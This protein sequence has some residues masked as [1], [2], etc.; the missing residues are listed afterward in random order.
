MYFLCHS[1]SPFISEQMDRLTCLRASFTYSNS[2]FSPS[3]RGS[4]PFSLRCLL[5]PSF[6]QAVPRLSYRW[7]FAQSTSKRLPPLSCNMWKRSCILIESFLKLICPWKLWQ[8]LRRL[9]HFQ[10]SC[11]I[12]IKIIIKLSG[13]YNEFGLSE[14]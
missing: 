11:Y 9:I 4:L 1:T 13:I 7:S 12:I 5:A 8:F 3:C 2:P 10:K 6:C 14:Y